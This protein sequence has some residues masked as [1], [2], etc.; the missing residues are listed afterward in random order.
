MS[1]TPEDLFDRLERL[2]IGVDTHQ[3]AAVFTVAESRSVKTALP[4]AHSKNLFLKDRK[5]RLFLVVA[6]DET[7]I[8]LKRLHDTIGASG[9]VSFGAADLLVT[10]LGV[11]PGSVTPFAVINDSEGQVQVVLDATLMRHDL[12][13]F[14]P[15]VNTAT[16]AIAREDFLAFLRWSGHEPLIADLPVPP[17]DDRPPAG[18]QN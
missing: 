7:R 17:D 11:Q 4:G 16:S 14:H 9:R 5:G 12:L 6:K 13:N 8:D 1:A 3:H 10:V 2:G 18:R 15:L